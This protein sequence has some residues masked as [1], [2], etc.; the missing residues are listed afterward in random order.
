[1]TVLIHETVRYWWNWTA[2]MFWQTALLIV[3]VGLLD[4]VT[5]RWAWPQVRYALWLLVVVKLVLP[6]SLSSPVSLTAGVFGIGTA[7]PSVGQRFDIPLAPS[8][9]VRNHPLSLDDSLRQ[10]QSG[11]PA[12]SRGVASTVRAVLSWRAVLMGVWLSGVIVFGFWAALRFR[13]LR[14]DFRAVAAP[15]SY[16][17]LLRSLAA[18]MRLR[19]A[20]GLAF[21]PR[22][23]SPAVFGILRPVIV[24]PQAFRDRAPDESVRHALLHE[25]AHVR[26]GDLYLHA[27]FMILQILYWFHPLLWWVRRRMQHVREL[28]CDA[29]VA[30]VLKEGTREYRET[31]LAAAER[32]LNQS[33]MPAPEGLGF[34]GL[35]ERSGDLVSRVR[36]LE[37]DAG[38]HS[39][40][41]TAAIVVI[42]IAM[43]ATVLP[44]AKNAAAA[45]P[46]RAETA[47]ATAGTDRPA[48]SGKDSDKPREVGIDNPAFAVAAEKTAT[49]VPERQ[50]LVRMCIVEGSEKAL[51]AL[52]QQLTGADLEKVQ[53]HPTGGDRQPGI[54][55]VPNTTGQLSWQ[56]LRKTLEGQ[57]DVHTL[58]APT[59]VT[60]DG[61]MAKL[62]VGEQIPVPSYPKKPKEA[63][64]SKVEY[65]DIGLT[66]ELTPKIVDADSMQVALTYENTVIVEWKKV[67]PFLRKVSVPIIQ[68]R[69]TDAKVTLAN[70]QIAVLRVPATDASSAKPRRDASGKEP[71]AQFVFMTV[72]R[73]EGIDYVPQ[74]GT[75]LYEPNKAMPVLDAVREL[76][77][78]MKWTLKS[79][80]GK[81]AGPDGES[82][83]IVAVD[84]QGKTVTFT[85]SART[86]SKATLKVEAEQGFQLT[87][88]EISAEVAKRLGL[89]AGPRRAS[90]R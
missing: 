21:S 52:D 86:G 7:Q 26:R 43:L 74:S 11:S 8:G 31:L 50:V 49:A 10:D 69:K 17:E 29:T 46:R 80:S 39:R 54:A 25:L 2:P 90:T 44:M 24:L 65:Q 20:P 73:L 53:P 68:S 62:F 37:K 48:E 77:M 14:R 22:V 1:M 81:T 3:I 13:R 79:E 47:A 64:Q 78:E 12:A 66:C 89:A 72:N 45:S 18:R 71:K 41:R 34:L 57:R 55:V 42:V 88:R 63:G 4:I 84:D 28:C 5:R 23:S 59:L 67:G 70:G 76:V 87:G 83:T 82:V 38:R 60:V 6:P 35:L 36:W 16:G 30:G 9:N 56:K 58:A 40:L 32:L 19:H 33:P 85:A 75:I 27:I 15:D 51:Q 61:Q